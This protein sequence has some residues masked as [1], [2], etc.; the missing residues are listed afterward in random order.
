ML[1]LG[2]YIIDAGVIDLYL[3]HWDYMKRRITLTFGEILDVQ[4]T[5][6]NYPWWK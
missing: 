5:G 4:T 3:V 2:N 6:D 1:P